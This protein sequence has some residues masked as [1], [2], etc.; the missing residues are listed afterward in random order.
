MSF[1]NCGPIKKVLFWDESCYTN[2]YSLI[3]AELVNIAIKKGDGLTPSPFC[4][5]TA[6]EPSTMILEPINLKPVPYK[7]FNGFIF[8]QA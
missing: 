5:H 4:M 8:R 7:R 6:H 1:F 2:W 3:N